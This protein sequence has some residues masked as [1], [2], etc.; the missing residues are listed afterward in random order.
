MRS[1][2]WWLACLV[3]DAFFEMFLL[4]ASEFFWHSLNCCTRQM[5]TK[6]QTL[7]MLRHW[8]WVA[9]TMMLGL[10]QHM[11]IW[12]IMIPSVG[13]LGVRLGPA[14]L[15]LS[16]LESHVWILLRPLTSPR[17]SGSEG[18]KVCASVCVWGLFRQLVS[19]CDQHGYGYIQDGGEGLHEVKVDMKIWRKRPLCKIQ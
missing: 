3:D 14:V 19:S 6:Y 1:S 7:T 10:A 18:A 16:G 9:M 5:Q 17:V 13:V 12:Q 4:P 2:T 8:F 11:L 15:T